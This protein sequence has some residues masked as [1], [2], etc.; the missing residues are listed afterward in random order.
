M[1]ITF[2][3]T[4]KNMMLSS[5]WYP[6]ITFVSIQINISSQFCIKRTSNTIYFFGKSPQL[7]SRTNLYCLGL[8]PSNPRHQQH[9]H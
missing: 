6:L 2:E 4:M 1:V 8:P 3:Y 9:C 7:I 5:Y